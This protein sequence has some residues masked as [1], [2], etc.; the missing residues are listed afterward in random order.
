MQQLRFG[1]SMILCVGLVLFSA[2]GLWAAEYTV[3]PGL[4]LQS[5]YDD[6]VFF[7]EAG[8]LE[9]RISPA[10][11]LDAQTERAQVKA[12]A[13]LDI[14][15]YKRLNE[16]D[17]TEQ[18]YDLSVGL[19]PS[20]LWQTGF[21]GSY[22]D[23]YTF[24]SA[25]ETAG[26]LADPSRRKKVMAEPY[27]THVFDSRNSFRGGYY[28]VKGQYDL[29]RYPDYRVH[30][31]S[32]TWS[33]GLM[34]ERT[35]FFCSAGISD[36]TYDQTGGDTTQTTYRG[37]F[38]WEHPFTETLKGTVMIGPMY[39]DSEFFRGGSM[40]SETNTAVYFDGSL[41]WQQE[42]ITLTA[43]VDQDI[44]Y[45]IYGENILRSRIRGTVNYQWTESL[46]AN[47]STA[48][49]RSETD[50]LTQDEKRQTYWVRPW[51]TYRITDSINFRAGYRYTWTEN[52]VT[53][54]S[55]ERHRIGIQVSMDWPVLFD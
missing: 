29:D 26:V 31:G 51:V 16:F 1:L 15:E 23:D 55:E 3:T 2:I 7:K 34:N 50:S 41:E 32:L 25:L 30:G 47:L 10:L 22:V 45:S 19:S 42:R 14:W 28:F 36:V 49:Y 5:T 21:S 38:G 4:A 18:F 52:R 20:E 9:L 17:N 8:D 43:H 53:D 12:S 48:F 37:V 27:V 46:R 24:V 54:Y 11:E 13:S 6:N 40:A 33:H 44:D 39:M 35:V